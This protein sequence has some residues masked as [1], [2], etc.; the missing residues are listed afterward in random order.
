MAGMKI[1]A[2]GL[3]SVSALQDAQGFRRRL[4]KCLTLGVDYRLFFR[5]T[6]YDGVRDILS[7]AVPGRRLDFDKL[8]ASFMPLGEQ[9]EVGIGGQVTDLTGIAP[10]ATIARVFHEAERNMERAE[11]EEKARKAAQLMHK[12]IDEVALADSYREIDNTYFGD[13][14][15]KPQPIYATKNP[16]IQGIVFETAVECLVVPLDKQ[17]IPDWDNTEVASLSPSRKKAKALS[18]LISNP[19][20]CSPGAKYLEVGLSWKGTTPK[21]A[22]QDAQFQGISKEISLESKYPD[23]WKSYAED[24]LSK[25]S[26]TEEMLVGKN[27]TL[28][29]KVTPAIVIERFKKYLSKN[30]ILLY[31]FNFESDTVKNAAQSFIDVKLVEQYP[32][33]QSQLLAILNKDE[34]GEKEDVAEET[35]SG[36]LFEEAMQAK[37]LGALERALGEQFDELTGVDDV[38]NI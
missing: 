20:F 28:N 2:R 16:M 3:R 10:Y 27:M 29:T 19:D 26:S 9:F 7:A 14:N 34:D 18:T 38:D 21:Q 31:H 8:E 17:G 24:K 12:D 6:E 33:I 5:L 11:V 30:T 25:L 35:V 15:A 1:I 13:R 32:D 36:S 37:S 4:S 23:L 22:G